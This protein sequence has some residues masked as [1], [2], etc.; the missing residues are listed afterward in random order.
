MN[1]PTA[2]P[3]QPRGRRDA[4]ADAAVEKRHPKLHENGE[5][6]HRRDDGVELR[7][8]RR[9]DLVDGRPD[10]LDADDHDERRYRQAGKV[11]EPAVPVRMIRVGR[12]ARQFEP[13]QRD[14]VARCIREVVHRVRHDGHRAGDESDDPLRRAKHHVAQNADDACK[15]PVRRTHGGV[16]DVLVVFDEKPRKPVGH[17]TPLPLS[18]FQP[19][20]SSPRGKQTKRRIRKRRPRRTLRAARSGMRDERARAHGAGRNPTQAADHPMR[21]R[22][23]PRLGAT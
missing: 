12:L 13:E 18:E 20:Y 23:P 4:L 3:A 1:A 14:D 22:D 5:H 15:R 2:K 10:Q 11:L 16:L 17:D 19:S 7:G 8:R 6:Q 9:E 21:P